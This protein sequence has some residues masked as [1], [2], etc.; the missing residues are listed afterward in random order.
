MLLMPFDCRWRRA[1]S[2]G[3]GLMALLVPALW[4]GAGTA[5]ADSLHSL[6]IPGGEAQPDISSLSTV[7]LSHITLL[8]SSHRG[9]LLATADP[10]G[11]V[12]IW[13]VAEQ[14]PVRCLASPKEKRVTTLRFDPA[15]QWLA[16]GFSDGSVDLHGADEQRDGEPCMLPALNEQLA[17]GRATTALTFGP[18]GQEE[19]RLLSI[20]SKGGTLRQ[21]SRVLTRE[22]ARCLPEQVVKPSEFPALQD[23]P[24]G[25]F[26]G[27]LFD[28]RGQIVII[29]LG[30]A[31]GG[32]EVASGKK[33]WLHDNLPDIVVSLAISPAGTELATGSLNGGISLWGI[34]TGQ[35]RPLKSPHNKRIR[36]LAFAPDGEMLVASADDRQMSVWQ[37]PSGALS[38]SLPTEASV[39]ALMFRPTVA[40]E[41]TLAGALFGQGIAFWRPA[42]GKLMP[43]QHELRGNADPVRALAFGLGGSLLASGSED[44]HARIWKR[45]ED[46]RTWTLQCVST[47][48]DGVVRAL[49]FNPNPRAA[50]QLAVV[51]D[52][53]R[54]RLIKAESISGEVCEGDRYIEAEV[55]AGEPLRSIAFSTDGA[56]LAAGAEDGTALIFNVSMGKQERLLAGHRDAITAVAFSPTKTSLLAT[57]SHDKTVRLWN[58]EDGTIVHLFEP[59]GAGI[60]ALSFSPDGTQLVIGAG[61][62][63]SLW[64]LDDYRRLAGRSGQG[65]VRSA[66]FLPD[67]HRVLIGDE[68]GGLSLW[69]T[70]TQ[71]DELSLARS[72]DGAASRGD[73]KLFAL[74]LDPKDGSLVSAGRGRIFFRSSETGLPL[75]GVLWAGSPGWASWQREG[76][77]GRLLRHETGGLLWQRSAAGLI[78]PLPPPTE[79]PKPHLEPSLAI[80][81]GPSSWD[82]GVANLK[83]QNLSGSGPALWL[84]VAAAEGPGGEA[85][86]HLSFTLPPMHMRLEGG[87]SQTWSIPIFATDGLALPWKPLELCLR[88]IPVNGEATPVR[89]APVVVGP[90]WWRN[91]VALA[92]SVT[93][94]V[95]V[96]TIGFFF[97]RR[98]QRM[99]PS[100]RRL[101][102]GRNPLEGRTLHEYPDIDLALRMAESVKGRTDL[103]NRALLLAGMDAHRWQ[104]ALAI[105][106]SPALCAM[107]LAEC[108]LA[109]AEPLAS[110]DSDRAE[111]W[112]FRFSMPPLPVYVPADC[113]L[114]VCT[115]RTSPPQTGISQLSAEQLRCPRMVFIV[116][117]TLP[118]STPDSIRK[119]LQPVQPA[120][121]FVVL[122]EPTVRQILLAKDTDQARDILR[123]AVVT[124]CEVEQI[125]PYRTEGVGIP[126]E[127]SQSFLGRQKELQILLSRH[128]QNFLLVGPRRMGKS[129]LL[130]ALRREMLRLY[131]E[132][133][134]LKF[135]FSNGSLGNISGVDGSL[136]ASS[137]DAFYASILARST[138]HQL[139]LLDEADE[140]LEQES[141]TRYG[142]CHVMRAL[143]GQ[144]RASFI[145]TGYRQLHEAV[146]TADHP[147]RNFG[148]VLRLDPLDPESAEKLIIEPLSAFGLK[149]ESQRAGVSWLLK[150][151]ACRPHL[152]VYAGSAMLRLRRPLRPPP[153][154]LDEIKQAVYGC[155]EIRDDF[156]N[157]EAQTGQ[158]LVDAVVMR[159]AL[160][161]EQ[162]TAAEIASFL[163]AQGATLSPSQVATSADRLY[164]FHYALQTD[165]GGKI[166]CPL[167][168]FRHFLCDVSGSSPRWQSEQDRLR[169]QLAVDIASLRT[170]AP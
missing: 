107:M 157:W 75:Q 97:V 52:S 166:S 118:P 63:L 83:V 131:P 146:R 115:S 8:E 112:A 159:A 50:G 64:S 19:G 82:L 149:L 169:N 2:Q 11:R 140:F 109:R 94:V 53:R 23:L 103:R 80:T 91:I 79:Q 154:R 155:P 22:S 168:L 129:S 4:M 148:E 61:S 51:A 84:R 165:A 32:W 104:R 128:Q 110:E 96:L 78:G 125:T 126:D 76:A 34:H 49:A 5:R 86:R 121:V 150:E 105:P 114:I 47:R 44:R 68:A 88:V 28:P 30:H 106:S 69:N 102:R 147:L 31:L 153:I 100:V 62:S 7:G 141:K 43:S 119:A 35:Q 95:L 14:R 60:Q 27:S 135:P 6:L 108:L 90:W 9:A 163:Q 116:D 138:A 41:S 156:G 42:G 24:A 65:N 70:A 74:A 134:V 132:V 167:R 48:Q 89:C 127:F 57:A 151:T 17:L 18:A 77:S 120:T 29:S 10:S 92:L 55:P 39:T 71:Q 142:F 137:P 143:S 113:I 162:A 124:Q 85:A 59:Q 145:L 136:C 45:G 158:Q 3:I 73:D 144:R 161:L 37:L 56:K 170:G 81:P 72:Q 122:S 46:G 12:C 26:E 67:G 123:I 1:I 99:D 133:Q 33:L 93:G 36:A 111:A 16:R 66:L 164:D 87:A 15:D 13:R 54:I 98:R 139:F 58:V 152:L 25:L 130:N 101:L 160:L 21:W 40:A 117:L 38:E 20:G